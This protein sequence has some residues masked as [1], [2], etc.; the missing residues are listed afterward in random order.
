M[1]KCKTIAL[2]EHL[3]AEN[4]ELSGVASSAMDIVENIQECGMSD[5]AIDYLHLFV[6]AICKARDIS[7]LDQLRDGGDCAPCCE[8]AKRIQAIGA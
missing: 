5:V 4:N 1:A 7:L 3:A 2:L 8:I 6:D